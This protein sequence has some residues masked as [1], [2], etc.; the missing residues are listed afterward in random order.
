MT[1]L[2]ERVAQAIAAAQGD[3]YAE[4]KSEFDGYAIA[5]VGVLGMA[6][7]GTSLVFDDDDLRELERMVPPEFLAECV[8]QNPLNKVYFRAGLLACR[9]YMARFVEQGGNAE[10][11]RSIRA[12]WWPG[13]GDDPG[14]P[15]KLDFDE[16]VNEVTD[17]DGQVS[18]PSRPYS[19]SIEALPIALSF[20]DSPPLP[21]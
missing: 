4:Y 14:A 17:A 12:N 1:D 9:E 11:A 8:T 21:A 5:A 16:L 2:V 10:I 15:R 7:M 19:A 3:A 6:S 18:Y 20:I 13:L